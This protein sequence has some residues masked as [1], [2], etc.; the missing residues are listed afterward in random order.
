MQNW[1]DE[2]SIA[3]GCLVE[4][5]FF[6]LSATVKAVTE[7]ALC[8]LC[9]HRMRTIAVSKEGSVSIINFTTA[10]YN[11]VSTVTS[12]LCYIVTA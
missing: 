2:A 11:V 5:L 9:C 6:L 10:G 7:E 8:L 12:I 1:R 3:V 4:L